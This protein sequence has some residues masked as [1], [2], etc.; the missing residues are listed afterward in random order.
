MPEQT[1]PNLEA[2]Y[3]FL[4]GASANI[5]FAAVLLAVAL[6]M[7]PK[8]VAQGV[9]VLAWAFFA[10]GI[11]RAKFPM[12]WIPWAALPTSFVGMLFWVRDIGRRMVPSEIPHPAILAIESKVDALVLKNDQLRELAAPKAKDAPDLQGEVHELVLGIADGPMT[13]GFIR[14]TVINHGADT[15]L[16]KLEALGRKDGKDFPLDQNPSK[17][18][19]HLISLS[20]DDVW[21]KEW[22]GSNSLKPGHHKTGWLM[23]SI[24]GD[25][26]EVEPVRC[27]DSR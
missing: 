11:I 22:F 18:R 14:V 21:L 7:G 10:F 23:F 17:A 9:A 12:V 3:R 16:R 19:K 13:C 25:P 8:R 20:D 2:L 26:L 5:F 6:V 4:E 27:G 15:T 1:N 24:K